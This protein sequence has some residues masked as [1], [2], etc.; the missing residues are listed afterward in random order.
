MSGGA[1]VSLRTRNW[2]LETR[3]P[4]I[5]LQRV[6]EFYP[7]VKESMVSVVC[8]DENSVILFCIYVTIESK[9]FCV[10]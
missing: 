3:V 1:G 7:A 5:V 10:L 6:E 2:K 9:L 8:S 4:R